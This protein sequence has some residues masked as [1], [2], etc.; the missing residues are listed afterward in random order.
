[1]GNIFE[2]VKFFVGE[3]EYTSDQLFITIP[4]RY[5]PMFNGVRFKDMHHLSQALGFARVAQEARRYENAFKVALYE[6]GLEA[7]IKREELQN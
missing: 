2:T 7:C 5:K 1:M 6:H 3:D 4:A